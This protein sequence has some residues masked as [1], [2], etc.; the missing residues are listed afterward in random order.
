MSM[1][2]IRAETGCCGW[3]D[4]IKHRPVVAI[5]VRIGLFQWSFRVC[6]HHLA[7]LVEK[8]IHDEFE[9]IRKNDD[10]PF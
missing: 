2:E 9:W 4:T 7:E 8:A 1:I 3:C 10:I 5:R 6:P